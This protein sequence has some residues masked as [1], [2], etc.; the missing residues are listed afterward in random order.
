MTEQQINLIIRTAVN[1]LSNGPRSV[2]KAITNAADLEEVVL[3]DGDLEALLN[4][5]IADDPNSEPR[6]KFERVLH[7]WDN[8]ENADWSEGTER[9]TSTRRQLIYQRLRLN[10]DLTAK[11][12]DLI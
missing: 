6:L 8:V 10:G 5:L 3:G 7:E 12:D 11:A 9:N 4:T 1:S 2:E